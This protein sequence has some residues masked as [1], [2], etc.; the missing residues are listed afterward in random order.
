[1]KDYDEK[2]D[3]FSIGI[4]LYIML[5]NDQPFATLVHKSLQSDTFQLDRLYQLFQ[6]DNKQFWYKHCKYNTIID[7]NAKQLICLMLE[8]NPKNRIATQQIMQNIWYKKNT[9]APDEMKHTIESLTS[10]QHSNSTLNQE[11]SGGGWNDAGLIPFWMEYAKLQKLT[12]LESHLKYYYIKPVDSRT[13]WRDIINIF[14]N[15]VENSMSGQTSLEEATCTL[16]CM[17]NRPISIEF[18]ISI[19][20]SSKVNSHQLTSSQLSLPKTTYVLFVNVIHG[21][22]KQF[23]MIEKQMMK[24]LKIKRLIRTDQI[25]IDLTPSNDKSIHSS[26]CC[27]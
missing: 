13:N 24:H 8:Y 20:R 22:I 27:I 15:F 18:N 4:M 21:D 1:M 7:E 10:I 5:A 25:P 6:N 2:C 23:E 16:Q 9:I 26:V 19:F 12:I 17:I 14:A 11:I 3:I